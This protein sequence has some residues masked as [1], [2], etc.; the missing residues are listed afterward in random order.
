MNEAVQ[1]SIK[2][3]SISIACCLDEVSEVSQHDLEHI[4]RQIT[5]IENYYSL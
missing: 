5:I 1:E 2:E 3:V 4:Q